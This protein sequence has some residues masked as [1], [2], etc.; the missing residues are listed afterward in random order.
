MGTWGLVIL[1]CLFCICLKFFI[2]KVEEKKCLLIMSHLN[3]QQLLSIAKI[4]KL[5]LPI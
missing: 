2:K 5:N 1:S 3:L 4:K